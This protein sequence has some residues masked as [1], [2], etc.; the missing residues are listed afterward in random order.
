MNGSS[1]KANKNFI[2]KA[3]AFLQNA[4]LPKSLWGEAIKTVY[5][6]KNRSPSSA[7]S[8]YTPY[9]KARNEKPNISHFRIFNSLAYTHVLKEKRTKLMSHTN[10]GVFVGYTD[11]ARLVRIYNP[12]SR[13]VKEYRDVV[14]NKTKR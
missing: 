4:H 8:G 12:I 3:L 11:T 14:I 13:T 10:L 7:L 9:E 1:E 5:Y 6:L 2:T